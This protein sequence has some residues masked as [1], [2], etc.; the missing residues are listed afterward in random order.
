MKPLSKIIIPVASIAGSQFEIPSKRFLVHCPST[1]PVQP[2]YY[3]RI[4][5]R[6]NFGIMILMKFAGCCFAT[7]QAEG[8]P[9]PV[10]P[11][12]ARDLLLFAKLK[13]KQIPRAKTALRNDSF[14]VFPE[15]V[16]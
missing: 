5:S 13:K 15:P 1:E 10:I 7:L 12:E 2:H 14:G 4:Q 9:F 8:K 6:I 3:I 11:S 16:S